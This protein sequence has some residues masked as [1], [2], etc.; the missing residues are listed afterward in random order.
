[1][2]FNETVIFMVDG[3]CPVC[4]EVKSILQEVTELWPAFKDK[5]QICSN[6]DIDKHPDR[7]EIMTEIQFQNGAMPAVR[8]PVDSSDKCLVFCGTYAVKWARFIRDSVSKRLA[9][10]EAVK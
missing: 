1:M 4:D 8:V 2:E 5:Y 10:G 7:I 3:V 6:A 9:K